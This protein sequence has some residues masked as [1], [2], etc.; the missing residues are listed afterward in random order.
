MYDLH[1]HTLHSDGKHTVDDLC[2]SAISKNLRGLA[3]TD[4]ADMNTF[5]TTNALARLSRAGTEIGIAKR[6]YRDQLNVLSGVELGGYALAPDKA[7][8]LL[9]LGDFDVVICSVH[10]V[11]SATWDVPYSRIDFSDPAISDTAVYEY[12]GSYFSFLAENAE[13][14]DCDVLGHISCPAR[15]ITGRYHR[16]TDVMHYKTTVTRILKTIIERDIALEYNTCGANTASFNY[17]DAQNEEILAL[18]RTL[19]GRKVTLGSDA[20]Q[21]SFLAR[22][23]DTAKKLLTKLGFTYYYYY[24]Q[25]RPVAVKLGE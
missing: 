20:H 13:I 8:R 14:C 2:R 15:Y 11:P 25:R 9:K 1:S 12:M 10:Y 7:D 24:E 5:D 23:F 18:Y 16:D 17:Y 21:A 4:H 22:G 6:H 19:G 3:I